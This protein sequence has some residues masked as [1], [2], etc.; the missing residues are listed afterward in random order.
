M[1]KKIAYKGLNKDLTCLGFQYEVGKTYKHDGDVVKCAEGGFHSCE[2][3]IDIFNYY[4]PAYSVFYEVEVSGDID[5]DE[6]D[7]K[8]ASAEITLK[9]EIKLPDLITKAVDYIVSK[10]EPNNKKH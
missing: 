4:D 9:A 10:C 7:S 1:D 8:I 6:D 2:S 3:P 5:S